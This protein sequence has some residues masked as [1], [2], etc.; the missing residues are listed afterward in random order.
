MWFNIYINDLFYLFI[1]TYTCNFA[2]D[3][4]LNAFGKNLE[5]LLHNLESDTLSAI[6]WFENNYM[7]LNEKKCHFLISGNKN[8]HLWAKV[9]YSIVRESPQEKLLG[10]TMDKKLNFNSHLNELCKKVSANVTALGRV[11]NLLPFYRKRNMLK[12]FIESQ[13]SYCPLVWMFCSR[14]LNR[15]INHIP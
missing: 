15:R 1:D 2:D 9:G 11:V 12:T 13:F 3:T 7:K 4:T 8:E 6:I 10:I 14:E 5:E